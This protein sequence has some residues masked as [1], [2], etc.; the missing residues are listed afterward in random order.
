MVQLEL[1][2]LADLVRPEQLVEEILRQNPALPVP[3]PI[4][5]LARLAGISKIEA[6]TSQGFEGALVANST[7][8]EGA[9]FYSSLGPRS[10]QRFTIGHELGHFLLPW[11]RQSS[12]QC[13]AE[14]FAPGTNKEWEAQANRFSAELLMPAPLVRQ[15]LV[16]YKDPELALL[17]QLRDEFE[18]S[19]EAAARRAVEL[20][21]YPCAVVFSKDNVVRYSVKS[22]YFEEWIAVRK[23]DSLPFKSPS[24]SSSSDPDV[25]HEL[26]ASWWLSERRGGSTQPETVYEQTLIQENGHKLTLLSY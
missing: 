9:I 5:E 8:S 1:I 12:F 25:W 7:K 18:A 20:S 23:G 11:H 22:S 19:L 10:R 13:T 4:E 2:E 14:D 26:D 6:F 24:R 16:A 17:I 21:E 15:R 3:V